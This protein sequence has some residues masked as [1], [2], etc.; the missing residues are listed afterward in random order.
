MEGYLW[1]RENFWTSL[2][3]F[4]R[5]MF[6]WTLMMMM[7]FPL[8]DFIHCITMFTLFY[9]HTDYFSS[10]TGTH[11]FQNP[12]TKTTLTFQHSDDPMRSYP[13]I[14]QL[15]LHLPQEKQACKKSLAQNIVHLPRKTEWFQN[16]I[17]S[18]ISIE[19]RLHTE[20]WWT[21]SLKKSTHWKL[22]FSLNC[23]SEKDFFTSVSSIRIHW[24]S[25]SQAPRWLS[26]LLNFR[27]TGFLVF[28][29]PKSGSALVHS[30]GLDS[31][32]SGSGSLPMTLFKTSQPSR[33]KTSYSVG[34]DLK[35]IAV[36]SMETT[37][38]KRLR[39]TQN[40]LSLS[41]AHSA[42]TQSI[43]PGCTLFQG[44]PL[45]LPHT[46]CIIQSTSTTP[47]QTRRANWCDID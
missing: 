3:S 9:A 45:K 6:H 11:P 34:S 30:S 24:I 32:R 29:L 21:I 41:T 1:N 17:C 2:Q 18:H 37:C 42:P 12:S 7:K 13:M 31:T 35:I 10:L 46:L 20:N 14:S 44:S 23:N 22:W 5:I 4:V 40:L 26:G 8:Q 33:Q 15:L 19:E 47:V 16:L 25:G 36:V 39:F 27:L 43:D 38:N 28:W